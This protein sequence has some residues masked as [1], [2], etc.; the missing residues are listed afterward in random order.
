MK[1]TTYILIALLAAAGIAA[2]LAP[3]LTLKRLATAVTVLRRSDSAITLTTGVMASLEINTSGWLP[4]HSLTD[5]LRGV[6]PVVQVAERPGLASPRILAYGEW[7]GQFDVFSEGDS[8]VKV[9]LDFHDIKAKGDK[10]VRHSVLIAP[11]NLMMCRIEVP[12]GQLRRL[13][14]DLP[15]E[16]TGLTGDSLQIDRNDGVTLRDCKVANVSL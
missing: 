8:I 5:T 3:P 1:K 4:M 2:F 13:W 11:D 14:S 16:L 9:I 6:T 15:V 12:E 7:S 10:K